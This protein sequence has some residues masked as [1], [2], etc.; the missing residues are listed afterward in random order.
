[1][2]L[3]VG[4]WFLLVLPNPTN[5]TQ[6]KAHLAP[7]LSFA[8]EP[9]SHAAP[10]QAFEPQASRY[11]SPS[12]PRPSPPRQPQQ[13]KL[14][15]A[16]EQSINRRWEAEHPA[17]SPPSSALTTSKR[18]SDPRVGGVASPR[19]NSPVVVRRG[20]PASAMPP[21]FAYGPPTGQG[22]AQPQFYQPQPPPTNKAFLPV[23]AGAPPAQWQSPSNLINTPLAISRPSTAPLPTSSPYYPS[24]PQPN[25]FASPTQPHG[26]PSSPFPQ[27]PLQRYAPT[28]AQFGSPPPPTQFFPP[29]SQST[30]PFVPQQQSPTFAP[31]STTYPS[32]SP[33]DSPSSPPAS[34]FLPQSSSGAAFPTTQIPVQRQQYPGAGSQFS[35]SVRG[36]SAAPTTQGQQY[37]SD[38]E[39]QGQGGA[40]YGVAPMQTMPSQYQQGEPTVSRFSPIIADFRSLRRSATSLRSSA[41]S[42]SWSTAIPRSDSR[43]STYNFRPLRRVPTAF[44][45]RGFL[46]VR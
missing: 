6:G 25:V 41:S 20:G 29:N 13:P 4:S 15:T 5:A 11:Q 35:G 28:P 3:E 7:P 17:P 12:S 19:L 31:A 27:Q 32:Q 24:Q 30:S 16:E 21:S 26:A 10:P 23:G 33:P 14:S 43:L 9:D 34:A 40:G 46:L 45:P 8:A 42:R 38:E 1:M 37:S 36:W 18:Q 2:I 22:Y 39:G 44:S